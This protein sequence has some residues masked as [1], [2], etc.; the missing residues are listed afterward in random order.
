[1]ILPDGIGYGVEVGFGVGVWV[2]VG[3]RVTVG[4][5]VRV[6]VLEAVGVGEGV[7]V[8]VA[9]GKLVD[10][11]TGMS[12]LGTASGVTAETGCDPAMEISITVGAGVETGARSAQPATVITTMT[13]IK[14]KVRIRMS[15]KNAR[16]G[17][18]AP[19]S[20]YLV[21]YIRIYYKE[22]STH[23]KFA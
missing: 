5:L 17:V 3:V 22:H 10:V 9:V 12:S 8:K 19:G 1:V 14:N 18:G 11:G 7:A 4:V 16:R 6:G 15:Q 13:A 2:R 21:A 23:V 20:H